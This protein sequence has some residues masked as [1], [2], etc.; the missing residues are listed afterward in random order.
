MLRS[1][2]MW[3]WVAGGW[4]VLGGLAHLGFHTWAFVLENRTSG[5]YWEFAMN[6]MKQAT[7]AD[8][9]RPSMWSLFRIYGVGLGLLWLFAGIA[10]LLLVVSDVPQRLL[11]RMSLLQTVFWT[12]AF[13]PFG[14]MEP[15]AGP[16]VVVALAVPL[17]GI[18][19]LTASLDD[20]GAG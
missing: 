10:D 2:R 19:Y 3:L 16:L 20:R 14:F 12:L 11:A 15:V 4:L 1:P 17:H 9:L 8:L 13:V 6:A 5:G 7:S 18:A